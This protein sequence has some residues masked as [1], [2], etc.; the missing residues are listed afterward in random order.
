[1]HQRHAGRLKRRPHAAGLVRGEVVHRDNAVG[2]GLQRRQQHLLHEGQEH[3]GGGGREQAEREINPTVADQVDG[4]CRSVSRGWQA[5]RSLA[6]AARCRLG[7]D[8]RYA[9][10]D[11]PSSPSIG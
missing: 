7:G 1:M 11:P 9:A 5:S 8:A 4:A 10:V 6:G 3:L 2:S